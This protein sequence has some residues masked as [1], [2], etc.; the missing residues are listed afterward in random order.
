RFMNSFRLL[1]GGATPRLQRLLEEMGLVY[2]LDDDGDY[3]LLFSTT[4]ERTH[5]VWVSTYAPE[6]TLVPSYEVW[7]LVVVG[8]HELPSGLAEALLR[9]SGALPSLSAQLHGGEDGEPLAVALSV[10]VDQGVSA[11][12]LQRVLEQL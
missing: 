2:T 10:V 4:D 12:T 9:L 7:A 3:R 11:A 8:V 6:L 1:E 5:L